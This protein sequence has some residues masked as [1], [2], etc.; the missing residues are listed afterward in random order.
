MNDVFL[1]ELSLDGQFD[2]MED[3]LDA[4]MPTIKCLKYINENKWPIS[5]C[6]HFYDCKIT[7]VHTVH[8][9]R[10]VR[11]DRARRIKSLLL[12]TTD[13][14]P[15]W[16]I[17]ENSVQDM[18]TDYILDDHNVS[19]TSIAEA[20][21]SRGVL[22]SFLHE[23]YKDRI[24]NVKRNSEE[25]VNIASISSPGYLAE[26]LWENEEIEIYDYLKMRYEGTRLD[27][28]EF[29]IEYGFAE[30]QKEE[31]RECMDT[32]EKFVKL[33]DWDAILQDTALHYK[34]YSP[35][36][37]RYNWFKG[38]TYERTTIDKFRCGNP[39]RCFGYRRGN[40]FYVLRMER[41]HRISDNG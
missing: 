28:S 12:K 22:I 38:T 1:N 30:F 15:F 7:S 9:L 14:P 32:F 20:A 8:D 27:F 36:S 4:S 16:D 11:D 10:G 21:E 25:M 31:I 34:K 3:F 41:D 33:E 35:S 18:E 2:S 13:N 5:K 37:E 17:E 19:G 6:T 23:K 39:K 40:I 24:L 29:Q 26:N